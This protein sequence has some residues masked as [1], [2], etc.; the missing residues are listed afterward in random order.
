MLP[1]ELSNRN[2]TVYLPG[3]S[4]TGYCARIVG[5][6]G[7]MLAITPPAN[8]H[9]SLW[10]NPGTRLALSLEGP[11]TRR[12]ALIVAEVV[13]RKLKPVPLLVLGTL[14][15]ISR[16]ASGLGRRCRTVAVTSGKGG[17]GKTFVATN[18]AVTLANIGY[19][20]ALLDGDLGTANVCVNLGIEPER[21][22]GD[23]LQGK[24][25]VAEI[26]LQGPAGVTVIP[27]AAASPELA[28]PSPWQLRRLVSTLSYLE[29]SHDF[30]IVD[31][32]AGLATG[33]ETLLMAAAE[34]LV[35]STEDRAAAL[36]AYGLIKLSARQENPQSVHLLL[37]RVVS[38]RRARNRAENLVSTAEKF[39]DVRLNFLG[40]VDHDPGV[41]LSLEHQ[42][43][44]V[45]LFPTAPAS[46]ALRTAT[47]KLCR[48]GGHGAA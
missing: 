29:E 13:S 10:V 5:V 30:V 12:D 3:A 11:T 28:A 35:V 22:M 44:C 32:G 18:L 24:G 26:A 47:E 46:R 9:K 15:E 21:H 38:A 23:I 25:E 41:L 48:P 14:D 7:R 33:V 36:D 20:V 40:Y 17:T 8:G 19:R 2:V 42:Q 16:P 1:D 43:P 34:I 27:G 45:S 37:N 6:R 31:T 39:L 4:K